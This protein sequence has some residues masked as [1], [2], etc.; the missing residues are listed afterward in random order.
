VRLSL[1]ENPS[2]CS[3]LAVE[4]I[5][6]GLTNLGRYT[7]SDA[8]T[9]T[10]QIAAKERVLPEQIVLGEILP[11]LGIQLGLKGGPG[12][13]FVYSQP[14][15]TDLVLAAEQ[16][17]GTAVAVD[18][19]DRLQN[20]LR[21][22]KDR[23]GAQ[24]RAVY[25][26]N[27]H[28]P[29]GTITDNEALRS[30]VSEVARRTLVIVDE[31]YLEYTAE[32]NERS[33][34][35]RVRAGDN[36]VVFRTFAKIYGLAALQMGYA[37]APLSLANEL[38]KQGMGAPHTLNRLAVVAAAA[39]LRDTDFIDT[40]RRD[41]TRERLRWHAALDSL[42]LRHSDSRGNF[43]FFDSGR[44]HETL[45]AAFRAQGVEIARSFPPLDRWARI[46]IGLPAENEFAIQALHQ[47]LRPQEAPSR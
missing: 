20:D 8:Q 6:H 17:G 47:I 13:Q 5:R 2:G 40:T 38:R 1:N 12:G 37:I 21:A 16:T 18:L 44:D 22:I 9:L 45:A 23:V 43:V 4:A 7:E 36:V 39:A 35:D 33:L 46:S 34:V 10:T 14:G 42:T 30:F 32:L 29:S 31:A 19:D 25:I 27:P 41:T 26:V 24:T 11:A 15:F 28:N 3:P